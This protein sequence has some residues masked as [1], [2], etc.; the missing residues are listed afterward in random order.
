MRADPFREPPIRVFYP[1][2]RGV[3]VTNQRF[4]A[5]G[6]SYPIGEL[7]DVTR[8]FGTMQAGRRLLLRM[9]AVEAVI[10]IA[11]VAMVPTLIAVAAA[12]GYLLFATVLMWFGGWRWPTPLELWANHGSQPALLF[13][14]TNHTEFHQVS[15]ALLRAI[16]MSEGQSIW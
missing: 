9:V 15:R 12:I 11:I 10:V 3:L 2:R 1:T 6:R 4:Q 13:L 7:T 14:S 8:C 16:E 5:S